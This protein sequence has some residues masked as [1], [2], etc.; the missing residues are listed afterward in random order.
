MNLIHGYHTGTGQATLRRFC[1][2]MVPLRG[3]LSC[4]NGPTMT[5]AKLA[6]I[7]EQDLFGSVIPFWMKH[8]IDSQHGGFFTCLDRDGTLYDDRKYMWLNGRQVWM[9]SRLYNEAGKKQE[10]LDA[11]RGG[12][13]FLRRH[14]FDPQGRCYF[15]LTR[16]GRPAGY[17][18]KPYGAVFVCI[19]LHEYAK[20]TGEAWARTRAEELFASIRAWIANPALMGRPS[21]EG[22]VPMSQLADVMVTSSIAL[23]L[24]AVNPDPAYIEIMRGCIAE[25]LAHEDPNTGVLVENTSPNGD[26]LRHMPEGRLVSPGHSIEVCWFL[27]DMLRYLPDAVLEQ[28]VL[29]ILERSL[30]LGWDRQ[31]GGLFYFMDL[32]SKPVMA[33]EASMKLWW[34]HTEAIYALVYAAVLTGE[35]KWMTWLEKVHHYTYDTFPDPAHGEWFGY[36]DRQGQLTHTL[37]GNNY[38]G[39]FH[40]PRALWLSIRKIRDRKDDTIV[41]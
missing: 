32:E 30:E 25:A 7:Y 29:R 38:K 11:A 27:L 31:H 39:C 23:E 28:R 36:C 4:N 9:L 26:F 19:G 21:L 22:A 37:K 1:R 33:L 3:E 17:Q 20:A 41:S 13:E 12:A 2:G 14:A 16:D 24:A 10:W 8:S 35:A 18:R 6:S 5:L 40:V 15:S 34:P